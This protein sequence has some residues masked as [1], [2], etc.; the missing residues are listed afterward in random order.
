MREHGRLIRTPDDRLRVFVSSMAEELGAERDAVRQAVQALRLSPVMADVGGRPYAPVALFRA[1]IEQGDVFVGLHGAS[2]GEPIDD[3]G[4]SA[5]EHEYELAADLPRLLYLKVVDERDPRLERFVER[6]QRDDQGSYRRFSSAAELGELVRDDLAVL[7][8]ERFDEAERHPL[9]VPPVAR[10]P[11]AVTPLVG[12]DDEVAAVG[13]LLAPDDVRLVTLTGPG[14]IGKTRLGIAVAQ[15]MADRF[16]EASYVPL[17]AL[18]DAAQ[19]LPAIATAL[20]VRVEA[21]QTP[22][23]ALADALAPS[24][25]LLLLDNVEHVV[26]CGPDLLRLLEVCPK[27]VILATSRVLLRVRGE[28]EFPVGPLGVPDAA[29]RL[30]EDMASSPAVELFVARA[31]EVNAR[32][33]LDERKPPTW[34]RSAGGSMVC[35]WRSSLPRRGFGF[36]RRPRCSSGCPPAWICSAMVHPICPRASGRCAPPSTGATTCCS[37]WSSGG[38]PN[39]RS[40]ST[41]GTWTLP[42]RF[43][44]STTRPHWTP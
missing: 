6:L 29:Q 18:T 40:S 12:R 41:D 22:L 2:Y 7:L 17:A 11:T 43:G 35:R 24:H 21:N 15:L 28:H 16:D 44:T 32:F 8:S 23:E 39:S 9:T 38:S 33:T 10:I 20:G 3:R 34:Q 19:V 42:R 4:V 31:T 13:R 14:G 5:L 1:Y 30:P 36:S 37:R 25:R 27:L 26:T